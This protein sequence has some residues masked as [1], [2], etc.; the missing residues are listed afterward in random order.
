MGG[1]DIVDRLQENMHPEAFQSMCDVMKQEY[2]QGVSQKELF[3]RHVFPK[4][5]QYGHRVIVKYRPLMQDENGN[6]VKTSDMLSNENVAQIIE[7]QRAMS[8]DDSVDIA[9]AWYMAKN[10]ATRVRH[11]GVWVGGKLYHWGAGSDWRMYGEAETDKELT[12]D[13]IAEDIDGYT[14][15]NTEEIEAFCDDF[16]RSGSYSISENNCRSFTEKILKFLN[17][18]V[19]GDY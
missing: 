14:L 19:D 2:Q 16:R 17:I 3:Q 18:S 4:I 1:Q 5:R 7:A 10:L 8:F 11:H 15:K 13:W 9:A 12:Q 6:I